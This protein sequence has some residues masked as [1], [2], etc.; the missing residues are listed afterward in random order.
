MIAVG[1]RVNAKD[2]RAALAKL[3]SADGSGLREPANYLR[4]VAED[5]VPVDTRALLL[6]IRV[7]PI[8]NQRQGHGISVSLPVTTEWLTTPATRSGAQ[9]KCRRGHTWHRR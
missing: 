4:I 5:L 9:G 7:V 8:K 3:L 6:S 1:I 2:A